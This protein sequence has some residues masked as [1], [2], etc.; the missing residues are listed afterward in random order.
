[1][2]L[3]YLPQMFFIWGR[4]EGVF[5]GLPVYRHGGQGHSL[6]ETDH[7][8]LKDRCAP[9]ACPAIDMS[10]TGTYTHMRRKADQNAEYRLNRLPKSQADF[11]SLV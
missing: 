6:A 9:T 11:G 2:P 3:F 5:C 7:V 8:H 1:M 10:G 4:E